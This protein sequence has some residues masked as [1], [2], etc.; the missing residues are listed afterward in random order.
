[1]AALRPS[2]AA[3][4]ARAGSADP[5]LIYPAEVPGVLPAASGAGQPDSGT[6]LRVIRGG[7]TG[8]ADTGDEQTQ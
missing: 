3:T 8:R 1:M 2:G 7:N 4:A 5:N 6:V